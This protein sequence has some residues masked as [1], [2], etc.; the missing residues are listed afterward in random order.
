M[1]V[2]A[3]V[4]PW[5]RRAA[6]GAA[7]L[8]LLLPTSTA[9][10]S[11]FLASQILGLEGGRRYPVRIR[12]F[13]GDRITLSRTVDTERPI[14]LGFL[15]PGG[16]LRLGD[17]VTKDRA[18]VVREV[19]SVTRGTPRA[20]LRGYSSGYVFDGD[21]SCRGLEFSD[22]TVPGGLGEFPAWLV[23]PTAGPRSG[24]WIIAVHGRAAP[25]GEALRILPTLAGSGHPTLVVSYRNDA[26][27]PP[28][29]DRRFHLGDTEWRDVEDAIEYARGNGAT[30]VVLYGWSMGGAIALN[31]LRRSRLAPLVSGLIMDCPV[32]D[33]IATITL[34]ARRLAMPRTWT[35]T[36]LRIV[37]QRLGIRLRT[38]DHRPFAPSMTI[39]TLVIVDHDDMTVDPDPALEFAR[40]APSDLTT[41]LA[42]HGAGHCRSWNLDPAGYETAVAKFLRSLPA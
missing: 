25:L 3:S 32:I 6:Y 34:I 33:W 9:G 4:S 42:T 20:G 13:S 28:S 19:V 15:W 22:V 31:L 16:H 27:A 23:P 30:D 35:W 26:N 11:W 5:P 2:Q 18:T 41:L 24:T 40:D 39:P 36:V 29:R 37:E 38:L 7:G 1:T 10:T 14:P 21:P 8:A 17:V 12:G